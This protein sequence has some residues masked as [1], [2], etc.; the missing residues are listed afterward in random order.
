MQKNDL[1]KCG[2]GL[3]RVLAIDGDRV[4]LIDCVKPAMPRWASANSLKGWERC[5]EGEYT[6]P[7][8]WRLRPEEEIMT[9]QRKLIHERFTLIAPVLPFIHK[10]SMRS[11]IIQQVA[12]MN[13]VSKQ[14]VRKYLCLYLASQKI[15]SL[16]PGSLCTEKL[17]TPDEKNFRWALNRY[18]YTQRRH[19]L[20]TT[21]TLML[22]DKYTDAN[23]QL[24]PGY[25]PFHRFRYYYQKTRKLSREII[26]RESYTA[27]MRDYRPLLGDGV[28]EIAPAP[29][30]CMLDSTVCDIYLV[31]DSG[32][33]VGRPVLTAC[34]DAFSGMCCGYSLCWEGGV[35]SLRGLMLNT[36]ADKVE[37]CRERGIFIKPEQWPNCGLPGVM[38]SDMGSEYISETFSSNIAELGTKV[39]SLPPARPDLKSRVEKFF[40]VVQQL[41]KNHLKWK[42]VVE[43]DYQERGSRDYRLDGTLNLHDFERVLLHCIVYYNFRRSAENYPYTEPMLEAKVKPNASSI[44]AWGMTQ[45]GANF[46]EVTPEQV[47]MTLL[48]RTKARFTRKGLIVNG[49]RYRNDAY[50]EQY[51]RGG[52]AV[53]AYN[54]DDVTKVWLLERG[55]YTPFKLIE[56]RFSGKSLDGVKQMKAEQSEL[57]R[58]AA[59][60]ELQAQIDLAQ[61]IEVIANKQSSAV[62]IKNIRQS[63][64]RARN[65]AHIDYVNAVCKKETHSAK[66]EVTK[67]E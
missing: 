45:P 10:E 52:D 48:P 34:V 22:K 25:P 66:K 9:E 23:G 12:E 42:G 4:L 17:L 24:V 50:T 65:Q 43:P 61:H 11:V 16:A 59:K 1:Y 27:Y 47:V 30:V 21:Y 33:I 3:V 18:F 15:E 53:A 29:G 40:D 20:T 51:L 6:I 63:R 19:T 13:G 44:F 14:T 2:D 36:I 55:E 60:E 7:D 26:G 38:I 31:D 67:H 35:Y 57:V 28:Q 62:G 46:I 8:A 49:I 41:Y 39:I 58:S 64:Q 54:P 37:W 56:Q 5:G 32:S